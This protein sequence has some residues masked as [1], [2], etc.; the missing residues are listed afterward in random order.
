MNQTTYRVPDTWIGDISQLSLW[1]ERY[2]EK[3][4]SS[5]DFKAI[6]VPMG[7][8]EQR[9]QEVYL[10]RVRTP[11][12]VIYPAQLLRMM[13]IARLHGS[14][15][16]HLTTRQEIQ[17]HQL[18]LDAL[19]PVLLALEQC[20]LATKGGGGNTIRNI[21]VSEYSG[22][23]EEETFDTTPYAIELTSR[24]IAEA[25]SFLLPRKMK[26]AFSSDEQN[27]DYAAINDVGLIAKIKAGERGFQVFVGGGAGRKSTTGFLLFDF[28]PAG[29]LYTLAKALRSFFS[30]H[31]NRENRNQARMRFIFYKMGVEETVELI[32]SYYQEERARGISFEPE[33]AK[34]ERPPYFYQPP[35]NLALNQ[36]AY[37]L[38]KRRYVLAQRQQGY[39]SVLIPVILGNIWL[40]EKRGSHF[41]RLLKFVQIF[42]EHT[43]R[44]TTT[45]NIR[46]RN[47]PE[48]SLPELYSLLTDFGEELFA[49]LLVNNIISC[50]GADTCRLGIGL[51][52]GL[53]TAIRR[54]LLASELEL[55]RLRDVSIHIS[56]CPNS[57]GQ[58]VWADL[59][60]SGKV[61]R[62]ERA[63]P[64]YQ[65][66]LGASRKE[67]P[68][69]A[70]A[71][72]S[73]SARDVPT[74]VRRLLSAYLATPDQ[75]SLGAY[76]RGEGR[77]VALQLIEEYKEIPS[78]E[79]ERS[80]YIDWGAPDYL[81]DSPSSN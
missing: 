63:Y 72:G 10:A 50:T 1:I 29:E 69:L 59:G 57:C 80:Y 56:G 31:G 53:A 8:Y 4:L 44:F 54:E 22:I 18:S 24:L 32:K 76:L 68:S 55:D 58:Q 52:K 33:P 14:E 39:Y 66:F 74:F 9:E 77:A 26:F 61:L 60:F 11:G 48:E 30:E 70:E 13:E 64:G 16:L 6:R 15:L 73:L 43:L 75:Q 28:L 65:V 45:Q 81:P 19:A 37:A 36:E 20:G 38:W 12:G 71:V 41:E 23:S 17:V 51:S 21:L 25:D 40:D 3:A 49:P 79:E 62:A 2:K 78:F 35:A 7:I 42:G 47:L 27:I 34:E 5:A 67:N 46:L